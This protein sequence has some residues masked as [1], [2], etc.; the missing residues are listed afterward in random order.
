MAKY[1][2]FEEMTRSEK[3]A[4][5]GI[6]NTVQAVEYKGVPIDEATIR[7]NIE[8][9]MSQLDVIREAW[10]AP[11]VVNSGYRNP[12]VNSIV[13]GAASSQHLT[14]QAADIISKA[15]NR[16][17]NRKLFGLIESLSKSGEVVFDQLIDEYNY[18]WVHVSFRKDG[19]NR[20]QILHLK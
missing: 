17:A 8:F 13:K 18:S 16:D 12:A 6:K 11:I 19:T 3:A 1:F 7:E 10:G 9:T 4:K 20:K 15:N 2:T 14:G 5:S